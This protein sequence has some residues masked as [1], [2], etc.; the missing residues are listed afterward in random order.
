MKLRKVIKLLFLGI[1]IYLQVST[2]NAQQKV[3]GKVLDSFSNLPLENVSIKIKNTEQGTYSDKNGV[4]EFSSLPTNTYLVFSMIG[5]K[6]LEVTIQK[7]DATIFLTPKI[8]IID[9]VVLRS[10]SSSQL[11][12]IASDQIYFSK[13]DIE[14]LPYILGEKDVI[15]LIQYT[16]GVQQATEGQSGLLVRGG[17][18][19]MNLSLLDNIYIHNTAHLGGIFSAVNADFVESLE[20]S[21]SSFDAQ[22]GGRL[23]SITDI[24]SLKTTD[25]T[26]FKGSIG[27][28]TAKITGNIKLNK[29]NSLLLSGR[30]TYLEAFK[31]FFKNSNSILGAKKNYFLYDYFGKHS[32][33]LNPK[34]RIETSVYLTKDNFTDNTKGRNRKLNWGNLLVGSTYYHDFSKHLKSTTSISNS[35]YKLSFSDNDFPFD[36]DVKSTFNKFNIDHNFVWKRDNG[37]KLKIGANY[38]FNITLPKRVKASINDSPIAFSNQ[39]TFKYH[40]ISG[41]SDLEFTVSKHIK[42]KTGIR[43]TS[44]QTKEN[45][46]VPSENFLAIEPRL[47]LKYML[48]KRAA[49]KLSYQRLNQFIHQA[50]VTGL[51]LPID[52]VVVSTNQF[53][54]QIA[55]QYSIGYSYE[56]H[57][58]QLNSALY[59]KRVSNYTEFVNGAVNNLFRNNIYEDIT[60]GKLNSYG[61]ELSIQKKTKKI[62]IQSSLTIS[63]TIARFNDINQGNYFPATF[64]RP[65]NLNTI[66]QYQL[67]KRWEIGALFLFTS[68]QNFTK[69]K[70]IRIINEEAIINFESKNASRYPNYHR[71]DLSCTYNFKPKNR[72]QSKLNLTI[73]NSYNNKNPFNIYYKTNGGAS[74]NTITIEEVRENLFPILPTL[75][76][77]FSF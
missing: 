77:I 74:D 2:V 43:L 47:S 37:L 21:K 68:G 23:S 1:C 33:E 24:K 5:Y 16:P 22:F 17:N 52:F 45:A 67:N 41:F 58:F 69:P 50:S 27:L 35:F 49:F 13:E 71:L 63:R 64:D 55:N 61:V 51:S 31:P 65:V 44:F 7:T 4:F 8:N 38:S 57:G 25:S 11:K 32:L 72:W 48:Q 28:L 56:P 15:K 42:A 6:T 39:E 62:T 66:L 70:D 9:E 12:K 18:G 3:T 10:F 20:F 46:L 73:Y 36:Y 34:N 14:K 19:S 54:P 26:T 29:K 30:R 53:K 59:Y 75:N 76:W 40:E 60:V